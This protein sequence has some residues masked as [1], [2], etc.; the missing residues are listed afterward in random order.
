MDV[1]FNSNKDLLIAYGPAWAIGPGVS[2]DIEVISKNM[3]IIK[4][5]IEN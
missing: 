1:N 4:D 2:A 5:F 3:K